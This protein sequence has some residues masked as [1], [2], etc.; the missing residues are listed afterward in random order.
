MNC[1]FRVWVP[2]LKNVERSDLRLSRLSN[3]AKQLF[4][5]HEEMSSIGSRDL[6]NCKFLSAVRDWR[7]MWSRFRPFWMEAQ[8]LRGVYV[9]VACMLV[10]SCG[11]ENSSSGK[12]NGFLAIF[13]WSMHRH[14]HWLGCFPGGPMNGHT[15]ACGI[16]VVALAKPFHRWT[17]QRYWRWEVHTSHPFVACTFKA[18]SQHA[19]YFSSH[20]IQESTN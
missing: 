8:G 12:P 7:D 2:K 9:K 16:A 17:Y 20:V 6:C 5:Q 1:F 4:L 14:V 15:W 10:C 13:D 19:R 3:F 18:L 11:S